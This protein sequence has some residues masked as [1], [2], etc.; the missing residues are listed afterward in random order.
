MH[1]QKRRKNKNENHIQRRVHVKKTTRNIH[2]NNNNNN[3]LKNL[4]TGINI[5]PTQT[6]LI[7]EPY[8]SSV[9]MK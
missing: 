9:R 2:N 4:Y 1:I 7:A 5:H 6:H 3:K 8:D